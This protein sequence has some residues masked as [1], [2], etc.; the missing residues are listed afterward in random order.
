MTKSIFV[1]FL[2]MVTIIGSIQA[3]GLQRRRPLC[4]HQM[5]SA[6]LLASATNEAEKAQIEQRIKNGELPE[7]LI[8]I[9]EALALAEKGDGKGYYQ[10][11][12]RYAKGEGVEKD[13][14]AAMK[15][16]KKAYDANYPRAI[17]AVALG[18]EYRL[19]KYSSDEV[20]PSSA[21][22]IGINFSSAEILCVHGLISD[23]GSEKMR[24][25]LDRRQALR[26]RE[27]WKIDNGITNEEFTA[28][29]RSDYE[30]A[31][32]LGIGVAEKE[33]ARFEK[34]IELAR[35]QV[36][37]DLEKEAIQKKNDE[38][39]RR[40]IDEAAG[41]TRQFI[42][43]PNSQK[44]PYQQALEGAEKSDSKSYY[45][46]AYYFAKGEGIDRDG[47]AALKFLKKAVDANDPVACY[48]FGMLLEDEALQNEDGRSVGDQETSRGFE[49]LHFNLR[50]FGAA[51]WYTPVSKSGNKCLTN[52]VAVAHVESLYQK[53]IDGGFPYATN[54]IAR[55]HKKIAD[56]KKRIA[57][58][59]MEKVRREEAA[60]KALS[61]LDDPAKMSEEGKA[62][63]DA[64]VEREL[65]N[66]WPNKL[67]AE[68][69]AKIVAQ[70]A[71]KFNCAFYG[72]ILD[73]GL[74][75]TNNWKRGSGLSL[76]VELQTTAEYALQKLDVEGRC[77]WISNEN[78]LIDA[79]ELCWI[80][81][82]REKALAANQ[83]KW[84]TE[85]GMTLDEANAKYAKWKEEHSVGRPL[86]GLRRRGMRSLRACRLQRQQ[87]VGR[88]VLTEQE[89]REREAERDQQMQQFLSIQE[90]LRRVREQRRSQ[91]VREE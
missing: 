19:G 72:N 29:V 22:L 79:E 25:L 1:A 77:V 9:E 48:T 56:C 64:E 11:A 58:K 62:A 76:I 61:L 49:G 35:A 81:E 27:S 7:P 6:A 82:E 63:R 87:D 80:S 37:A 10:L 2:M 51:A 75:F 84:S 16:L 30:R 23:E 39:A 69:T 45:W 65:W 74:T 31:K 8:P 66:S 14:E 17:F 15:F 60:N 32:S 42:P 4:Q 70:A 50:P 78:N 21:K 83:L 86:G 3:Q 73:W 90:E 18:T 91:A 52:A 38:L 46:L 55:L 57:E 44:L 40:L 59:Q 71:E 67:D 28:W 36:K 54:D 34:R 24:R 47:E 53:A 20:E 12:V 26:G 68:S 5:D 85:H 13:D 89:K 43:F 88:P 41:K 33:L